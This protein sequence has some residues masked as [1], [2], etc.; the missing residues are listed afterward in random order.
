MGLPRLFI[1]ISGAFEIFVA[2]SSSWQGE[3]QV[4]VENLVLRSI[5]RRVVSLI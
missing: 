2:D 4:A 5:L 3:R 1:L